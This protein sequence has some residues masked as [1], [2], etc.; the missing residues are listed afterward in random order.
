MAEKEEMNQVRKVLNEV[1]NS[2]KP[3]AGFNSVELVYRLIAPQVTGFAHINLDM[4]FTNL[5]QYA[6]AKCEAYSLVVATTKLFGFKKSLYLSWNKLSSELI[7]NRSKDGWSGKLLTTTITENKTKIE[8]NPDKPET[9]FLKNIF[10][11]KPTP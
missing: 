11:S 1:G 5:D 8:N 10:K 7:L 9:G 4:S 6:K 2:E 3:I